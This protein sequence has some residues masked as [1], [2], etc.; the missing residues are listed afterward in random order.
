[1]IVKK[2]AIANLFYKNIQEKKWK[3]K[4]IWFRRQKIEYEEFFVCT[5]RV[6]KNYHSWSRNIYATLRR[7]LSVR[8]CPKIP[9][10]DCIWASNF[11]L[12]LCAIHSYIC[13]FVR[14]P[15]Y[16]LQGLIYT[17]RKRMPCSHELRM[18]FHSCS[19]SQSVCVRKLRICLVVFVRTSRSVWKNII[20]SIYRP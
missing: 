11:S 13:F 1:M 18:I 5:K 8:K 19:S 4:K 7:S 20:S 16:V 15:M 12:S 17:Q 2:L 10:Y 9:K 14:L 6:S 3:K